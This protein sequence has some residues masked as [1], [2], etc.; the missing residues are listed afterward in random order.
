M[1]VTMRRWLLL[2]PALVT[3]CPIGDLQSTLDGGGD[4]APGDGTLAESGSDGGADSSDSAGDVVVDVSNCDVQLSV[5]GH[6]AGQVSCG[7]LTC[8][9][10]ATPVCCL[11]G[12][13]S[14]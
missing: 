11:A 10:G 8:T 12:D 14:Y 3:G 9:A 6:T 13:A 1:I 2:L 4:A 5:P 7:P